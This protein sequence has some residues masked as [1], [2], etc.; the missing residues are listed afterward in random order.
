MNCPTCLDAG[1]EFPGEVRAID[2]S[3]RAASHTLADGTV[4]AYDPQTATTTYRCG[5]GHHWRH[6]E[7]R[8]CWCGHPGDLHDD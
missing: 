4:H 3:I 5:M 7:R 6:T 2:S 8:A 1:L